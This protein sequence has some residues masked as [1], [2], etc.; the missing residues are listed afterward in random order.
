M[1]TGVEQHLG[2]MNDKV[3][4]VAVMTMGL[5]YLDLPHQP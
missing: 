4:S 2:E 5:L 3:I 1:L